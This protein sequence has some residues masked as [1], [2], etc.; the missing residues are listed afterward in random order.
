MKKAKSRKKYNHSFARRMTL[1][2]MLVLFVM[3]CA[4]AYFIY[5][6]SKN[7]VVDENASTFHSSMKTSGSNISDVMSD[8]EV[9]VR[10]NVFDVER[11]LG[12]PDQ[13]PEIM[14]RIVEQNP[15]V[16]S[17]GV[18]FVENYY[19]QKGRSYCPYA[20]EET[21]ERDDL[22]IRFIGDVNKDGQVSVSDV[23]ATVDIILGNDDDEPWRYD[24]EAADFNTDGTISVSDISNL[25]LFI[26]ESGF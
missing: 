18:S 2:V 6:L 7:I 19:S 11:S 20:R 1:W 10:N 8:V 22:A 13:L 12:Q 14:R 24:H 3:M 16:R 4:L 23:M 25:A 21:S 17:C 9:A 5:E 26:L 15:W